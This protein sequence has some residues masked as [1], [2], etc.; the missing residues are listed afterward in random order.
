MISIRVFD[1][2]VVRVGI[3]GTFSREGDDDGHENVV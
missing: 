1:V 3:V 2:S